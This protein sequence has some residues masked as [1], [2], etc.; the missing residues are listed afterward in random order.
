LTA[1]SV[2]V[3]AGSDWQTISF[4]VNPWNLISAGLGTPE[5]ALANVDVFRLF[6]N[7]QPAFP[8][9]NVG[10]APVNAV[11]GVDNVVATVP[12]PGTFAMLAGAL[13]G[14]AAIRRKR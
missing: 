5:G 10:P 2:F 11:L 12:E 3:P 14:I 9:P 6:H 1:D 13:I 4:A 8:G 7:P